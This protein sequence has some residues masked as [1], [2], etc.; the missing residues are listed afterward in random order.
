MPVLHAGNTA[1]PNM[2]PALKLAD[3]TENAFSLKPCTFFQTHFHVRLLVRARKGVGCKNL[4]M[5]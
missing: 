2:A 4:S 3:L 1:S 5:R